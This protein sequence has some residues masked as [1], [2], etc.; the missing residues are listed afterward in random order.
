V[1][2]DEVY[3]HHLNLVILQPDIRQQPNASVQ[4]IDRLRTTHRA[5]DT[6]PR[7]L[8][9]IQRF[10]SNPNPLSIFSDSNNIFDRQ[11][12]SIQSNHAV[13]LWSRP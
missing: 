4:R 11:R 1:G 6:I 10:D 9:L 3:L 8:H 2:P 7:P 12:R 13:I 5:L